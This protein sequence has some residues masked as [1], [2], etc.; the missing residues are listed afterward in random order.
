MVA[1]HMKAASLARLCTLLAG[2]SVAS[3][4]LADQ[5]LWLFNAPPLEQL[6]TRYHFSPDA[7]WFQHLRLSSV[8]FNNG[9][10]GS[11]VSSDGLVITNQ[12]VGADAL[13]AFTGSDHNYVRDGFYA[14]TFAAEKKCYDLELNVLESIEDVTARVVAAVPQ[15]ASPEEALRARRKAMAEIEQESMKTTGWRSD[16]VTL[17]E[18]ASYQLYRYKQYTDVRLVFAPEAGIAFFGGD[19]DNFEYPRY[20]LDICLFRV[21]ENGRPVHPEDYLRFNPDGP[22]EQELVFVSGNPGATNRLATVAAMEERRDVFLP[23]VLAALYRAEVTLDTYSARSSD[24]ARKARE[25][26]LGLQNSRKALDGEFA[27]LLDSQTF[28]LISAREDSLQ[29]AAASDPRFSGLADSYAQIRKAIETGRASI[30][31]YLFY[32]GAYPRSSLVLGLQDRPLGFNSQLFRLA[33]GLVR[34]AEEQ[35]K[36]N[37]QRLPE[38]RDT[39][40][41]TLELLLFSE[42]PIYDDLEI[43]ELT[44]SLT[45]LVA[46]YGVK[47][48]VVQDLLQGRSPHECAY[49]LISTTRLKDVQFRR[50][51]YQGGLD[52]INGSTDPMIKFARATDAPARQAR[53]AVEEENAVCENAYAQ[54]A[55]ARLAIEGNRFAPDA[56]F[57]LRLSFGTVEGYQED[58]KTVPAFTD[59]AG[60]YQRAAQHNNRAPFDLPERWLDRRSDLNLQTP[61]NFVSTADSVGGNSGSPFVNRNGEFVGILFDGNIQT[62]PWDYLYTD[63]QARAVAVDSRAILETLEKVYQL[64]ALVRELTGKGAN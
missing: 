48:P 18:G 12:H 39:S 57:N 17:F 47:D 43:Q 7:A 58:G 24:N 16:V 56:T 29:K 21:Y 59:F 13:Q 14:A 51:L 25:D 32:E 23:I 33:R 61:F 63:K 64:P 35:K 46:R 1:A 50:E 49:E 5:G 31:N 62:L 44:D 8:R 28:Q 15:G 54:I 45:D 30:V 3:T 53:Q 40:R 22:S 37:E 41:K 26:L 38:Y 4:T 11:F 6:E 9:A 2:F 60:L 34:A 55:K 36:E 27:G 52:A 42:A 20:N 19:P 10:S